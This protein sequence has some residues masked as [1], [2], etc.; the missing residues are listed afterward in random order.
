GSGGGGV[1]IAQIVKTVGVVGSAGGAK[2]IQRI[3]AGLHRRRGNTS[4]E[5]DPMTLPITLVVDKEIC[6]VFLDV[7]AEGTAKLVQIEL[8]FAGGKKAARIQ[9]GVSVELENRAVK[10]V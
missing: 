2:R 1:G 8:F 10:L 9:L 3:V 4:D 5:G 7:A 6:L